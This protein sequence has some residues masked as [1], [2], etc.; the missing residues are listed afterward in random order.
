MPLTKKGE[1]VKAA[2]KKQYGAKKGEQVFYATENKGKVKD[3][4]KKTG[5]KK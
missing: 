3:L 4:T 2:M 5:K 1:K